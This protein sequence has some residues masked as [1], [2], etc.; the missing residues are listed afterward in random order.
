MNKNNYSCDNSYKKT[1]KIIDD[2]NKNIK[3]CYVQGPTGPK[4]DNGE[5]GPIGPQG[6]IG[7]TA[8]CNKSSI[9]FLNSKIPSYFY[10][11]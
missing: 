8:R 5:P 11:P 2:T 4:G 10:I 9:I 3:I 6:I 1:Q 7:P